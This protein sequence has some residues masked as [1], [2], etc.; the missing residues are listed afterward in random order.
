MASWN[1][2]QGVPKL[3]EKKILTKIECCGVKFSHLNDLGALKPA[4]VYTVDTDD[5]VYTVD[6]VDTVD[7]VDAVDA[8]NTIQAALHCF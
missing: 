5:M 1:I 3:T 6:M 7:A 2:L 4:T 8:L